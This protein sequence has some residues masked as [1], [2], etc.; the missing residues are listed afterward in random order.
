MKVIFDLSSVFV[1]LF[2]LSDST[3]LATHWC[4]WGFQDMCVK[5]GSWH[6][7]EQIL[8]PMPVQTTGCLKPKQTIQ[9]QSQTPPVSHI[10]MALLTY[11]IL[12]QQPKPSLPFTHNI[13]IFLTTAIFTLPKITQ[14]P[15]IM[16]QTRK[17]NTWNNSHYSCS[18]KAYCLV[19]GQR[20]ESYFVSDLQTCGINLSLLLLVW[21]F[22]SMAYNPS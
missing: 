1:L 14:N 4:W 2:F 3:S 10:H 5:C 11:L 20:Y 19:V 9:L 18:L 8:L 13:G 12:L 17:T 22:F 16:E 6:K 21:F 15:R 7:T